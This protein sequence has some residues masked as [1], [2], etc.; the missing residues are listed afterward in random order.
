[1]PATEVICMSALSRTDLIARI[2]A[3]RAELKKSGPIHKRDL[4]K[5]IHRMERE[6]RDYD[7]FQAEA[8]TRRQS[9]LQ[10]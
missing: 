10:K 2:A 8:A 1:M 5:H 9:E 4:T 6:L 3:A 7:R